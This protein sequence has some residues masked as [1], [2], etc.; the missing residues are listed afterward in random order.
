M[1]SIE[2]IRCRHA[3][4]S[5]EPRPIEPALL[6]DLRGLID[7]CND[8]GRLHMQLIAN[9]PEAFGGFIAHYSKFENVRNY[10]AVVGKKAADLE[11][12]AGYHGQRVV[13]RAQQLGL[14]TCWVALTFSKRKSHHVLASGEKLVCVIA[15]GYGSTQGR[16]R[17]TKPVESLCSAAPGIEGVSFSVESEQPAWFFAGVRA[18]QLAPTALNQQR[19]RFELVSPDRVRARS[20]GGPNT[21][22]DLG[23]AKLHFEIGAGL[24]NFSWA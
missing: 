10:V 1:E 19:F 12:R 16:E 24:E 8:E 20:L 17:K 4:R 6:D 23:I 7:A 14:N 18:A 13:L 2:A 3:V 22:V 21:S 11:E 15:L 5:Y 9:E